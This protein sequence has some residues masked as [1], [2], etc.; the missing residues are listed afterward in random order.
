MARVTATDVEDIYDTDLPS[1]S[2]DAHIEAAT[3][4]VDDVAANGSVSASRLAT[5]EKYVAAHFISLQDPRVEDEAIGSAEWSYE[6]ET[7]YMQLA[8]QLDPTNT[9]DPDAGATPT[10]YVPEGR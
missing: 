6:T 10:V 8:M 3:A 7:T 5:I 1:A 9:L 2:L 4:L